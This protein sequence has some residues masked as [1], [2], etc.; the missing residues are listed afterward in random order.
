MKISL[1]TVLSTLFFMACSESKDTI[2]PQLEDVSTLISSFDTLKVEFN[3]NIIEFDSSSYESE[4]LM[5]CWAEGRFVYCVGDQFFPRDFNGVQ[6]AQDR[7]TFMADTNYSLTLLELTD[8]ERNRTQSKIELEFSTYLHLDS[9]FLEDGQTN[10]DRVNADSIGDSKNW[11]NG[12]SVAEAFVFSGIL[13]DETRTS[14]GKD[15]IDTYSLELTFNQKVV[16]QVKN[17]SQAIRVKF[18]GPI[19]YGSEEVIQREQDE[20]LIEPNAK[21][22]DSLVVE[23]DGSRH[24]KGFDGDSVVVTP[25]RYWIDIEFAEDLDDLVNTPSDYLVEVRVDTLVSP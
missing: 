19:V 15:F 20:L 11:L 23:I 17:H 6:E 4:P 18:V 3:E 13:E 8:G 21:G 1:F 25:L 24:L 10:N 22:E 5:D 9:D 16:V 2:A 14:L 7:A 12:A